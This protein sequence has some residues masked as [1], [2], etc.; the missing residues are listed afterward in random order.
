MG[1]VRTSF[2]QNRY[3]YP[4]ARRDDTIIDDYHGHL[5]PDPYRWLE[6]PDSDETKKFI[7][8]QQSVFDAYFSDCQDLSQIIRNKMTKLYDFERFSAPTPRG[9]KYIFSHNSGLQNQDEIY[10]SRSSEDKIGR[11][12]MNPNEW[13][14]DGTI[15]LSGISCSPD[16]NLIAYASSEAGSDWN[17]VRFITFDEEARKLADRLEH[18]KF[19]CFQWLADSTGGF[20]NTYDVE[21]KADGTEMTGNTFCKTMYH[22]LGYDQSEDKLVLNFPNSPGLNASISAT[23]D[24]NYLLAT[25]RYGCKTDN[26]VW[27]AKLDKQ[28]DTNIEWQKILDTYDAAY[29]MIENKGSMFYFVT[30]C[31]GAD[32]F[33]VIVIDYDRHGMNNPSKENWRTIIEE[34]DTDMIEDCLC[35]HGKYLIVNRVHHVKNILSIHDLETGQRIVEYGEDALGSVTIQSIKCSS[36][37]HE[38]FFSTYSYT[39]PQ[40]IY[41]IDLDKSTDLNVYRETN[42]EGLDVSHIECEQV[43]YSSS[44]DKTV[45]IPMYIVKSKNTPRDGTSPL[46]LY[47]YGGF[48]VNLMPS[49]S[50]N[51]LMWICDFGGVLAIP[52][53][54]G[55]C[56][57]GEQWHK[58]GQRFNKMNSFYDFCDAAT[59]LVENKYTSSKRLVIHGGSNGGLLAAACANLRPKLFRMVISEVGV[60]D[61][62]RFHTIPNLKWTIGIAWIS[63]YGCSDDKDDFEYLIKYSPLHN[64]PKTLE[65]HQFPAILCITADHD[66]RVVPAHTFKYIA[67][68]QHSIG[69]VASQQNPLVVHIES[70]AGHGQ[71]KPI[72]KQIEVKSKMLAMMAKEL[73]AIHT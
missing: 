50:L 14:K 23:L 67:E 27:V 15:A 17:T 52:N 60:L 66:D 26:A 69:N 4:V 33:K 53:I 58:D 54:R 3:N 41:S 36:E 57:Y 64:I 47:G 5:I 68:L 34:D 51:R 6:D 63:D 71:G 56:E 20:Y 61:M 62:L 2:S 18:V 42:F 49:F 8:D 28:F 29:M 65:G 30:N 73:G 7:S 43:F 13:S 24:G 22:R 37:E 46:Y 9:G 21:K 32:R 72:S 45:K 16:N 25:L 19:S 12:Y 10:F 70:R 55:G 31:D 35:A 11:L 1:Q 38:I 39:S 44:V 40:K 59:F 48:G